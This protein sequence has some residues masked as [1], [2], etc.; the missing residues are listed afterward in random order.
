MFFN[1]S[2]AFGGA[3]QYVVLLLNLL[4]SKDFELTYID[5]NSEVLS[6]I[7]RR[8]SR[9]DVNFIFFDAGRRP[10]VWKTVQPLCR[11]IKSLRPDITHCSNV[12]GYGG[13]Y[14]ILASRLAGVPIVLGTFHSATRF[15]PR[16]WLDKLFGT[17][18]DKLLDGGIAVSKATREQVLAHRHIS[19]EKLAVIYNGVP[20]PEIGTPAG[21]ED[22]AHVNSATNDVVTIGTAGRLAPSKDIST[23]LLAAALLVKNIGNIHFTIIGDGPEKSELIQLTCR[24]N[25]IQ[26]V[27]FAGWQEPLLPAL[28]GLD[29]FVSS[30][31]IEGCPMAVLEA[32]ACGLPVVATRVGGVPEV[33]V[34]GQTGILVPP[35]D[36][37]SLA[38]AISTLLADPGKR[39]AM[40]YAGRQ[41][42]QMFFS[43]ERMI[44][45]TRA[46][47]YNL[48][49]RY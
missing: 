3:E 42:A 5:T 2:P 38:D 17:L 26:S 32:M 18:A 46:Y 11:V 20:I 16:T 35:K 28:Q 48:L 7:R 34:D 30:S 27:N 10:S 40:G 13:L 12:D 25:L 4:P 15:P 24:Y 45:E 36:P 43:V 23:L 33:V 37:Q 19:S 47:Y 9:Q 8:V 41:R 49:C 44:E 39:K 1:H 29:I 21:P 14:A 6:A 31:I 22:P